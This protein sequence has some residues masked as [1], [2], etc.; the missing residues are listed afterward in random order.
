[1]SESSPFK[2]PASFESTATEETIPTSLKF[3]AV[4]LMATSVLGVLGGLIRLFLGLPLV[5]NSIGERLM[6]SPGFMAE[7]ISV[8]AIPFLNGVTL[9]GAVFMMK[10]ARHSFCVTAAVLASIPLL[11]PGVVLGMPFGILALVLLHRPVVKA[12]FGSP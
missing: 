9:V 3:A 1:M 8:A 4:G 7:L 11:S 12:A 6:Q 10:G 5:G 2:P